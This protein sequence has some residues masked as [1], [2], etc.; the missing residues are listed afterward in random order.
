MATPPYPL[1]PEPLKK[2]WLERNPLWK[3]PL[4]CL[5]LL[6]LL[7]LVGFVLIAL[8]SGTFRH[9]DVYKTA[10]A[11]AAANAQVQERIGQPIESGWFIFGALHLNGSTGDANFSI[12]ISGRRGKGQ[13]RVVAYKAGV[14]RFTFLQ[15]YVEGQMGS[16]DLLGE[17][18]LRE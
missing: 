11:E 2:S 8:I 10:M 6:L 4:G 18:T 9:S 1:N 12:P 14:W 17:A 7:G 3:I 15:V 16:I 13:I 5:I